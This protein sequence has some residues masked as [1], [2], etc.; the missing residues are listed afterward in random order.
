M[1]FSLVACS[2][3][4]EFNNATSIPLTDETV[5]PTESGN[6]MQKNDDSSSSKENNST[7]ALPSNSSFNIHF[8]DVGQADSAL[9]ECDGHYMLIDGGNKGDSNVIYSVLKKLK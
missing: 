6:N 4:S 5:L 2:V 1:L 8:I 7:N 9:I 3:T